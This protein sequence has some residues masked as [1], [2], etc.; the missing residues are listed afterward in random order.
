LK[1]HLDLDEEREFDAIAIGRL[2][3]D[4]NPVDYFKPWGECETFKKYVGGSPAN[5]IV[6]L[7]RLNKRVGFIGC[8]SD[9]Q[10]GDYCLKVFEDE[11]IDTSSIVRARHGESLGLAFTEIL[12]ENESGL[13]MY[14]DHV[15]DLQLEPSDV[16]EEYIKRAKVLIVSGSALSASPSRE[17]VLKAIEFARKHNTVI[18]FDIDYRN[19]SWKNV[20]EISLYYL[21]AARQADVIMGSKE[22][23][24]LM[25]ALVE[26]LLDDDETARYWLQERAR[27][28]I[29]KHGKQGSVAYTNTGEYFKVKPFPIKALKSFGGGDGYSSAC[30]F[31]LLEGW[32]VEHCLELG[33]ACAS[34]LV[35]SHGCSAD[36][37]SL[38]QIQK[39]IEKEKKLYGEMITVM[40]SQLDEKGGK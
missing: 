39:F 5:T 23:F 35:A 16:K 4:F 38:E 32:Q 29:I 6:G 3:I 11:G 25:H 28:V 12:S 8:I 34:M 36:M 17:A 37:P 19:Y 20:D 21:L 18:V 40:S 13:I 15:A 33:S 1:N 24:D 31:G 14:R 10:M 30:I 27:L 2:C 26:P 9:D 22:E 7:A